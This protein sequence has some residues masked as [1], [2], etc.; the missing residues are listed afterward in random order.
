MMDMV[1]FII[2]SYMCSVWI[3]MHVYDNIC[4][5]GLLVLKCAH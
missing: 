4:F 5:L 2:Y 1:G 3:C